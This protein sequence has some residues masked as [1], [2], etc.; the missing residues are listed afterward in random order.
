MTNEEL[1]TVNV[2][3]MDKL[4]QERLDS[5]SIECLE[6]SNK[7]FEIVILRHTSEKIKTVI[8]AQ[9]DRNKTQIELIEMNT[10]LSA[11]TRLKETIG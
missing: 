10:E 1:S 2:T 11:L 4:K 6:L 3:D 9:M 5:T 7:T 8:K